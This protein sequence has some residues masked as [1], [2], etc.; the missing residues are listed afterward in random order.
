MLKHLFLVLG[1][2]RP[3][4]AD[5]PAT[6]EDEGTTA[7]RRTPRK[8]AAPVK[9]LE[10]GS[11]PARPSVTPS[12]GS[13]IASGSGMPAPAPPV[14][15]GEVMPVTNPIAASAIRVPSHNTVIH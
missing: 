10:R 5:T 14:S 9:I 2:K 3:S 8:Q 15:L 4:A 13:N 1:R 7:I 12:T 6:S 11:A